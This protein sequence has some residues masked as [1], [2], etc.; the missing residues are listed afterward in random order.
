MFQVYYCETWLISCNYSYWN[1]KR[2][3][4]IITD[5]NVFVHV[6]HYSDSSASQNIFQLFTFQWHLKAT[7]SLLAVP[8]SRFCFNFI[9]IMT[10]VSLSV[11]NVKCI[12]SWV[13]LKPNKILTDNN[14]P[15]RWCSKLYK[16][17]FPR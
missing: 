10:R 4:I 11:E 7:E 3:C 12:E 17:L 2:Y 9:I 1:F 13:H 16:R 15:N 5:I 6:E 8:S 14:I